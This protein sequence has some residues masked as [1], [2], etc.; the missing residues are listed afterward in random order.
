MPKYFLSIVE[1]PAAYAEAG[2][3][4]F[5]AVM[6]AHNDFGQSVKDAGATVLS[7]EALQPTSTATFLRGTRTDAVTAVDNPLPEV[8]EVIGGYYLIEA[9]DDATALE[10]AK[11]CPAPFGYVEMRPIWEFS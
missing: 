6:K 11:L 9:P 10:L 1:D 3:A 4:D 5:D 8:K 2:T 7:G